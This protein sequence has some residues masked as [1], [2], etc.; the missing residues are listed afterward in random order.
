MDDGMSAWSDSRAPLLIIV[1]VVIV[2][3]I[4]GIARVLPLHREMAMHAG[5]DSPAAVTSHP[6]LVCCISPSLHEAIRCLTTNTSNN[7]IVCH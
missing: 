2:V 3:W 6:P 5:R 4:P 1:V 7:R